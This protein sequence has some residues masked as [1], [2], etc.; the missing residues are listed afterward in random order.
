MKTKMIVIQLK[1]KKR[2]EEIVALRDS[3]LTFR[4]I[5]EKYVFGRSTARNLY[6]TECFRKRIGLKY[7][8]NAELNIITD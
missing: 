1:A 5:G 4:E 8:W 6:E 2:R 3:G 7:E